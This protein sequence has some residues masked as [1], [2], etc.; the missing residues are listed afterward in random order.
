MSIWNV[1]EMAEAG[2][3]V[4]CGPLQ[5]LPGLLVAELQPAR[6][7]PSSPRLP[8]PAMAE[9]QHGSAFSREPKDQDL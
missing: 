9:A 7:F 8:G 1:P 6:T 3:G 5:I 2:A 4:W